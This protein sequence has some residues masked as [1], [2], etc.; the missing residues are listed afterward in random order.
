M[1]RKAATDPYASAIAHL[2]NA[3]PDWTRLIA[4]TGPCG[5][6]TESEREPYEALIRAIAYQQLHGRA[7]AAITARFLALYPDVAFPTPANILATDESILRGCGFSANKVATIR[8]I[9]EKTLEGVVPMRSDALSLTD[10]ELIARLVTLR[11]VGRWTVEMILIFTL[12]RP[13]VLPVDD[14]GVREGWRVLKSLDK[15]PLPKELGKIGQAWS[16]HRSVAAWYLWQ[17][18]NQA[19]LAAKAEK[20]GSVKL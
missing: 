3:D 15:Q 1:A 20:S 10:E 6:Q 9:A 13:D 18:A 17:A 16:P 4:Q 2:S 7:A 14:F 5:L 8:G 11:G 19:K 12:E